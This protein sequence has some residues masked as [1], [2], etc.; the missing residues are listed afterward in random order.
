MR[1]TRG[2]GS[3]TTFRAVRRRRAGQAQVR[4]LELARVRVVEEALQ[5]ERVVALVIRGKGRQA[6]VARRHGGCPTVYGGRTS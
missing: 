4:D 2:T 3:M 6:V 5:K 1:A